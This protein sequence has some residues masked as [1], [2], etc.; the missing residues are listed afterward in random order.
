MDETKTGW[1]NWIAERAKF[2]P[3]IL[4]GGVLGGLVVTVSTTSISF[5]F[6][7][8]H[9]EAVT[10]IFTVVLA[11]STILLWWSTRGIY[12]AGE[13]QI[14]VARDAV[15]AARQSV[16][17]SR[18]SMVA[19]DRAYIHY[20]GCNWISHPDAADGSIFWS[21]RSLWINNGNTPSRQARA[22]IRFELLD[23]PLDP[24]FA[25]VLDQADAGFPTL[26]PPKA[27]IGTGY[28]RIEGEDLV[29]VREGR[30]HFYIWGVVNYHDV[31][32]DTPRHV[33][34][35]CVCATNIT[36]NPLRGF[37]SQSNA[38]EII[39]AHYHQH[40]CADEDCDPLH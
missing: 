9:G 32:P 40:N 2:F 8:H 29:A 35:F 13:R 6:F 16:D 23:A 3:W 28:Y 17:I 39:F 19:S 15:E 21:I 14:S 36:G 4:W 27:V 37:N 7:D 5:E 11:S 18:L 25:F 24:N 26:F 30:K 31:F 12:K 22:H 38:V 10:A 20:G 33:T 1:F 34:K